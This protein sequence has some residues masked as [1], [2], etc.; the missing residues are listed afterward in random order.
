M[1]SILGPQ[2]ANFSLT[3]PTTKGNSSNGLQTWF[4]D[5]S[6]AGAGD[7]TILDASF[8]NALVGQFVHMGSQLG[9]TPA[10][11]GDDT[12]TYRCLTKAIAT[13]SPVPKFTASAT[14]PA[15]PAVL[16]LWY[17]TTKGVVSQ[18]I[19]DGVSFS[20]IQIA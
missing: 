10:G 5:C 20:W 9:V 18:Y 16:D 6:A 4:K 2:G 14:A 19:T 8:L 15:A 1:T 3:R 12:F 7:G 17:D 11:E 13:L